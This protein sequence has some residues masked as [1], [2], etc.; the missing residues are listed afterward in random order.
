MTTADWRDVRKLAQE[1]MS[2][3]EIAQRLGID[4]RTV[5][6]MALAQEPP[7]EAPNRRGS[8]LDPLMGPIG[9]AL[10]EQPGM[11]AP[12]LTERLRSEQ[13]YEGSVDLVRRRLA[14]LRATDPNASL[15]PGGMVEWDWA[16]MEGRTLIG[17]VRRSVWALVASLPFSGAQTAHFTLDATLEA[18]L[19]GHVRVFDWLGGTPQTGAYEHL[20]AAVA[21]RDTRGAMR[22]NKRFRALRRHYAFTSSVYAAPL[23]DAPEEAARADAPGTAARADDARDT[24]TEA[25]ERLRRSFWSEVRFK[26]LADLDVVYA[27]WRDGPER[28]DWGETPSGL[29]IAKR[30][31]EERKALRALPAEPFDFAVHRPVTPSP[32][33]YVRFAGSNYRVP[34]AWARRR[35]EVNASRDRVWIEAGGRRVAEY[36]RS[37]KP[38]A[39]VPHPPR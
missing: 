12:E 15:P 28:A 1:G 10:T 39:W 32:D 33:G 29:L 4:R 16:E 25:V 9:A 6:R 8:R 5:A 11:K 37:Y 31:I 2:H 17:G 26:S 21:K 14:E 23:Q 20:P 18:F 38:R 3:R 24:L 22:W 34:S 7:R 30:L 36:A 19:E 27:T 13:G 35:V